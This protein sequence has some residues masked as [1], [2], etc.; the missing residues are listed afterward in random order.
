ML[1]LLREEGP[2]APLK[3]G[4]LFMKLR[5]VLILATMLLGVVL[6]S[7]V[8]LAKDKYGN[9]KP[10]KL[11]GTKGSDRIYGRGGGDELG[12]KEGRDWI[13]GQ[14]GGDHMHGGRGHDEVKGGP[15]D[16][17]AWGDEGKDEL[18]AES[19]P[20]RPYQAA[21][22]K[23]GR[24]PDKLLGGP[25]NDIF[26]ANNG[27]RDIIRGGPG[28]DKAYVDKVDK[29][30]GVEKVVVRGG[31][32]N[33]LVPDK[34]PEAVNDSESVAEDS[35]ATTIDV[36]AN[37]TNADGGPKTIESVTQPANGT[38]VITNG[39]DDLTYEPDPN[40]YNDDTDGGYDPEDTFKYTLNGGSEATVSM[41]VTAEPL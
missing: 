10:N 14:G 35:G 37:D 28:H 40:Y 22:V 19:E 11:M 4:R 8:V 38:V 7:G 1:Q 32:N 41:H 23:G 24:K 9:A 13:Y 31:G 6:L 5:T 20:E 21:K 39:G 3:K 2:R 16:D 12:G 27:K 18:V 36:L 15:G 30:K 34:P 26:R 25:G 33:E 17:T 29:V